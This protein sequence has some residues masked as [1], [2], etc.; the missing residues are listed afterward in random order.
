M[1]RPGEPGPN[2]LVALHQDLLQFR[3]SCAKT[4]EIAA[5]GGV[6]FAAL[7]G[8]I[9]VEP[10]AGGYAQHTTL[11]LAPDALSPSDYTQELLEEVGESTTDPAAFVA[12]LRGGI[13]TSSELMLDEFV[14]AGD[15]PARG[16]RIHVVGKVAAREVGRTSGHVEVWELRRTPGDSTP[17]ATISV[18]QLRQNRRDGMAHSGM[19]FSV[20]RVVMEAD[21]TEAP[22]EFELLR[23]E[24]ATMFGTAE[25]RD[26]AQALKTILS[27]QFAADTLD[28]VLAS[29]RSHATEGTGTEIERVLRR[30]RREGLTVQ[31]HAL[32]RRAESEQGLRTRIRRLTR[33][34]QSIRPPAG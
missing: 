17:M 16:G 21:F 28:F 27:G 1:S 32:L 13:V 2:L 9:T 8:V 30:L 14:R 4:V 22:I 6:K 11:E 10:S 29:L 15:L 12:G 33:F 19:A 34:A 24:A 31:E 5:D 23:D 25:N 18:A 26:A 3:E 20:G 7:S